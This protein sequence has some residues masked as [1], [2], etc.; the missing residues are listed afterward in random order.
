MEEHG[1]YKITLTGKKARDYDNMIKDL[2]KFKKEK[3]K[4]LSD[5]IYVDKKHFIIAMSFA[6]GLLFT[7]I[8]F[9]IS[10]FR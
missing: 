3:R 4:E 7:T 9:A 5:E 8:I 2:E 6:A 10:G 1:E